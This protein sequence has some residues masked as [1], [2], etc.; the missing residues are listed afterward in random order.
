MSE[1]IRNFIDQL[2]AGE[3]SDAK[4]SLENELASRSFDALEEYKQLIAQGIFGGEVEESDGIENFEDTEDYQVD[5]QD[6]E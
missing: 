3:A 4:E 2:A 5:V 6:A 1:N